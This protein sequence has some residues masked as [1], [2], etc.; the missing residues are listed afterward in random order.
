MVL[1]LCHWHDFNYFVHELASDFE[2]YK[3]L[4]QILL[5]YSAVNFFSPYMEYLVMVEQ[6]TDDQVWEKWKLI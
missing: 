5:Q 4:A 2:G 3:V 6:I 1:I